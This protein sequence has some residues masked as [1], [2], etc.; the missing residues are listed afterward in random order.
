MTGIVG[1][2]SLT[3][4]LGIG[5][6]PADVRTGAV[7]WTA[8]T[9]HVRLADGLSWERGRSSER[10]TV[11]PGRA[12]LAVN[13]RTYNAAFGSAPDLRTP[14][15]IQYSGTTVWTGTIDQW[16]GSWTGG[17]KPITRVSATEMLSRAAMRVLAALPVEAQKAK[18]PVALF[19]L[20]E[21]S[22]ATSLASVIP[23][24]TGAAGRLTTYSTVGTTGTATWGAGFSPGSVN[25]AAESTVASFTGDASNYVYLSSLIDQAR[26]VT[27]G[28]TLEAM[29]LPA[30][31]PSGASAAPVR[32]SGRDSDDWSFSLGVNTTGVVQAFW[33]AGVISGSITGST[34][35][36]LAT[37]T[38]VALT[39]TAAGSARMYVNGTQEGSTTSVSGAGLSGVLERITLG[40]PRWTGNIANVAVYDRNLSGSEVADIAAGRNGFTGETTT[41]RAS[42][43]AGYCGWPITVGTGSTTMGPQPT[44]GLSLVDAMQQIADTEVAPYWSNAT[45]T[46]RLDGRSTRYSPGAADFTIPASAIDQGTTFGKSD[47]GMVNKVSVDDAIGNKSER[48]NAASVARYDEYSVS[49]SVFVTQDNAGQAAMDA[50]AEGL[51]NWQATPRVRS[52]S[53]GVDLITAAST[54]TNYS[55]CVLADVGNVLSITGLPTDHTGSSSSLFYVEGVSDNVTA[56]SWMRTFNVSPADLAAWVLGDATY[57]VLGTTT[58][59]GF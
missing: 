23:Q 53:I 38:H 21:E 12:S 59:L 43:I 24:T 31:W 35:V 42:R 8:I 25:S 46:L 58:R 11:S 17:I 37:W 4:D 30:S 22:T 7:A 6:G 45:A 50:I 33:G 27:A 47:V 44:K 48:S 28:V 16:D 20:D 51:A 9:S 13:T 19:P 18:S 32:V 10:D 49:L 1:L 34:G 2:P 41:A 5:Y 40:A 26:P 3:V 14:I 36:P 54:I 52:E 39:V 55:A 15:R 56:S 29:I 57:G